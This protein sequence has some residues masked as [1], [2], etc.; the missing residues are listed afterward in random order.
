MHSLSNGN[1]L[2][3][4][5]TPTNTVFVNGRTTVIIM[6]TLTQ[7][8]WYGM[9]GRAVDYNREVRRTDRSKEDAQQADREGKHVLTLG[10]ASRRTITATFLKAELFMLWL[11]R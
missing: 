1:T 11:K 10:L 2:T 4:N 8:L 5:I 3:S 7:R 6:V 9:A